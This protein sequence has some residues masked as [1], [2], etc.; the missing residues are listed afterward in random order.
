M[1]RPFL[2]FA[3]TTSVALAETPRQVSIAAGDFAGALQEYRHRWYQ[4]SGQDGNWTP[5]P[6]SF[7]T[8][9]KLTESQRSEL[10]IDDKLIG[11]PWQGYA[12]QSKDRETFFGVRLGGLRA[13][14]GGEHQDD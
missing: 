3:L 9:I 8:R 4:C 2:V 10:I 5:A 11:R 1:I 7:F 12:R 6:D 14:E 13:K